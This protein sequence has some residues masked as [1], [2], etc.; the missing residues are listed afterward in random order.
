MRARTEK[1]RLPLIDNGHIG[2]LFAPRVRDVKDVDEC[3]KG[4]KEAQVQ[5]WMAP[6]PAAAVAISYIST[7]AVGLSTIRILLL[8]LPLWKRGQS[9]MQ[10]Q[11]CH[12]LLS[13]LLSFWTLTHISSARP[14]TIWAKRKALL[15]LPQSASHGS[16]HLLL[17]KP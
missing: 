7:T 13:L 17:K 10:A 5:K 6:H 14:T 9:V 12:E 2:R 11:G 4:D 8:L 3:D 1:V 15:G 16:P